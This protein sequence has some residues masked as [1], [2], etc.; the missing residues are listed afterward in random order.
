MKKILM[1]IIGV[2]IGFVFLNSDNR[3]FLFK[4]DWIQSLVMQ[5]ITQLQ[6][7]DY[8]ITVIIVNY[9][10]GFPYYALLGAILG[11]GLSY[12]S[13][14]LQRFFICGFLVNFVFYFA[15][16]TTNIE[17]I[18][19]LILI[20]NNIIKIRYYEILFSNFCSL[21]FIWLAMFSVQK[22]RERVYVQKNNLQITLLKYCI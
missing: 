7:L 14:P 22:Y 15:L 1:F 16:S 2:I 3:H 10:I 19:V 20:P 9:L 5:V 12:F 6:P 4:I 21:V 13:R 11:L 8:V 18:K 17:F